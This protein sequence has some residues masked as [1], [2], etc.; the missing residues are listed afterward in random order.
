M[1]AEII[2]EFTFTEFLVQQVSIIRKP[3]KKKGKL[4]VNINPTGYIFKNHN[5]YQLNLIT[6]VID[7]ERFTCKILAVG[8]FHFE[9]VLEIPD[10]FY[11]SALA[12]LFPYIR[13]YI[14]ALTSLSGLEPIIIPLINPVPLKEILLENT[15]EIEV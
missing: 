4:D 6:E 2:T 10:Y 5:N 11:A 7:D 9:N 15:Q 12:I 3:S 8:V 13:S 14:S 1:E